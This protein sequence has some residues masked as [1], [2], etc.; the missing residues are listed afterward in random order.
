MKV[1][2]CLTQPPFL[3]VNYEFKIIFL[4]CFQLQSHNYLIFTESAIAEGDSSPQATPGPPSVVTKSEAAAPDKFAFLPELKR[5][6]RAYQHELAIPGLSG[7]NYI[8]CAPTGS[9]KT[10]VAA[11]II[12]EHLQQQQHKKLLT[13]YT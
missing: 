6:L 2:F 4:P 12:A 7:L 11:Y 8:I 9:G 1:Q 5:G 3:Y 13:K 10:I